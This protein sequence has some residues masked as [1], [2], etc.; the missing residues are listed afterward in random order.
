MTTFVTLGSHKSKK[1]CSDN[2]PNEKKKK[3]KKKRSDYPLQEG[4]C[5]WED[6]SA[7]SHVVHRKRLGTTWS[8]QRTIAAAGLW[9]KGT[10]HGQTPFW[11]GDCSRWRGP[12]EVSVPKRD[13]ACVPRS[14]H[15]RTT[16]WRTKG[17]AVEKKSLAAR[18]ELDPSMAAAVR[19]CILRSHVAPPRAAGS[20][21]SLGRL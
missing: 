15:R 6:H 20:R 3:K 10:Q 1:Q 17:A 7:G 4:R 13:L 11:S 5:R 9:T 12:R 21:H 8:V 2:K 19:L 14:D 16:F 18:P